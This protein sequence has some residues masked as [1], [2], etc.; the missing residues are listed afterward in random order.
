MAQWLPGRALASLAPNTRCPAGGD[1]RS[2]PRIAKATTTAIGRI[3]RFTS[4]R[5]GDGNPREA[6]PQG[7]S[8]LGPEHFVYDLGTLCAAR[9]D[10]VPVGVR[11]P[12]RRRPTPNVCCCRDNSD[13]RVCGR[14]RLAGCLRGRCD[15]RYLSRAAVVPRRYRRCRKRRIDLV[16]AVCRSSRCPLPSRT[17]GSNE[18]YKDRRAVAGRRRRRPRL[19]LPHH[20]RSSAFHLG[21]P[22]RT[23]PLDLRFGNVVRRSRRC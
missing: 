17:P 15:C 19:R 10:A 9:E 1:T 23:L 18:G 8:S 3:L 6:R 2:P 12:G 7:I 16:R 14:R 20:S 21:Y 22:A 11:G 13:P 4:T 5:I